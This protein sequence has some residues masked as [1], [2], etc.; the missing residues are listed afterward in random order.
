MGKGWEQLSANTMGEFL[1]RTYLEQHLD[2]GPAAEAAA[3]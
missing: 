3:G 1:L 2:D